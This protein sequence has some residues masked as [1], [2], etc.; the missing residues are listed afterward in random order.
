VIPGARRA[1]GTGLAWLAYAAPPLAAWLAWW[2]AFY[3]GVIHWDPLFQWHF[4]KIGALND[5]HPFPHTLLLVAASKLGPD[6]YG[7]LTLAHVVATAL[8]LGVALATLRRLGAPRAVTTGTSVALA[9][10]PVYAFL[11]ISAWKDVTMGVFLLA[12]IV[13]LLGAVERGRLSVARG[14]A[15]GAALGGAWLMRHNAFL[16]VLP[17]LAAA[18]VLLA[19]DRGG[20]ASAVLTLAAVVAVV[21]GPVMRS[22]R[23]KPAAPLL[24]YSSVLHDIGAHLV[25]GTPLPPDDARRLAHILPLDRWRAAFQPTHGLAVLFTSGLDEKALEEEQAALVPIWLRLAAARPDVLLL[26]RLRVSEFLWNPL[27]R[28]GMGPAGP[29]GE[30]VDPN[31]YGF[32]NHPIVPGLARKLVA[33]KFRTESSW[34]RVVLWSPAT[35]LYASLLAALVGWRRTRSVLFLALSATLLLN[36]AV[37]I[38]FSTSQE[39]RFAWPAI[40]LL[41]VVAGLASADWA[42]LRAPARVARPAEREAAPQPAGELA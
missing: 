40:L 22:L 3:P 30:S 28:A 42:R 23:V 9:T 1:P 4:Y 2:A 24:R 29:N 14:L 21:R 11:T 36:A 41:P 13:A 10:I 6:P 12:A 34:A 15:L 37:F 5:W 19:R 17:L 7:A 32:T 35:Y 20:L 38:A 33:V 26:S 18:A 25:A 8:L 16:L 27:A 39:N 31:F